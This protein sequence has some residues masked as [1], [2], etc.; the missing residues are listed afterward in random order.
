MTSML[1]RPA[2]S[3]PGVETGRRRRSGTLIGTL[4]VAAVTAAAWAAGVGLVVVGAVVTLVWAVSARGDDGISTP[5]G[6]AGVVWLAAHHAPVETATAT[7][8]LLP[9]LLLALVLLLLVRAGRWAARITL[10]TTLPDV[11]LLVVAGVATYS[12]VA[13][14]VAEV[15]TIGGAQVPPLSA[16]FWAALVSAVGLGVGVV[17][18]SGLTDGARDRIPVQ[19]RAAGPVALAAAGVLACAVG[20]L[21]IV[22]VAMHWATVAGMSHQLAPSAG[23]AIGLVLVQLMYLPNLLVWVLSY[24]AGPGFAVGGGG[25]V[26][27]FSATG[28]LLPGVPVLGA[29]PLDAPAP[30]PFLLL[31]PVLAGVVGTVVLRRRR[32]WSVR[33]ESIIVLTAAALVGL[34][35]AVL[36]LLAGGSLGDVRLADLGP[37]AWTTAL[38]ITTLAAAGG[39]LTTFGAH[40][41]PLVWAP[42]DL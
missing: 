10:T 9:I 19:V 2:S 29:I 28:A 37:T 23:D 1:E 18:E 4:P 40:L 11:V 42:D 39:L 6:A 15:A 27:P 34:A 8:T 22:A 5:V 25:S 17:R 31:V 16:L 41:R 3:G 12:A 30:A 7:V 26:D 20:V 13:V 35:T 14:L 38:A 21:A 36:C 24:L 32:E 33:D